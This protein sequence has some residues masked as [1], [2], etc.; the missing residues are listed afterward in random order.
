M[1]LFAISFIVFAL[2]AVAL[3]LGAML[4]RRPVSSGCASVADIEDG[5]IRCA[6]CTD[7]VKCGEKGTDA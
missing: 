1:E 6:L 2:A 7:Y 4:G 5:S 3:A